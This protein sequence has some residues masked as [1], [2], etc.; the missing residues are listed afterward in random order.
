[1][2][3]AAHPEYANKPLVV[4]GNPE[5]RRGI[6]LAACPLAKDFGVTTAESVKE[7]LSKCPGLVIIKPRMQTYIDVSLQ[8]TEILKHYTDLVEPYSIDEQFAD[9]TDS[10]GLFGNPLDIAKSIQDQVYTYTGVYI[11]IGISENKVLSKMACDN[12]AKK[13]DPGLCCKSKEELIAQLWTLPVKSIFMIGSRMMAHFNRRN[14]HTIGDLARTPLADFKKIMRQQMKR[15]SDIQA[16]VLWK[17]ANGNGAVQKAIGH[18]MTLPFEITGRWTICGSFCSSFPISSAGGRGRRGAGGGLWR[19]GR[20]G[21]TSTTLPAFTGNR[22]FRMRRILRITY[23]KPPA[24]FSTNNGMAFPYGKS[25][26]RCLRS[27]RTI[28]ISSPCSTT[29][30]GFATWTGRRIRSGTGSAIRPL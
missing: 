13:N 12:I 1:V 16:E 24:A 14:I 23:T 21:L 30:S 2:E 29:A 20:R 5:E 11:R 15:Q 7:A 19:Q 22:G 17:I 10:V 26:S 25:A 28:I 8:I 3:K 4:A 18:Q 6:I 9:I 27:S